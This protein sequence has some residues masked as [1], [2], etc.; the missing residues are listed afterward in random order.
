MTC[1]LADPCFS[2]CCR[3]MSSL[4][5]GV[6]AAA[7]IGMVSRSAHVAAVLQR[8]R[9][10]GKI[11]VKAPFRI[12]NIVHNGEAMLVPAQPVAVQR[13]DSEVVSARSRNYSTVI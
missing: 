7:P 5:V 4:R 2:R 10:V 13:A 12:G 3:W 11:I 6:P 1:S 8:R 9:V